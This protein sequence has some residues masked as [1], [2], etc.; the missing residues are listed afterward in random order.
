MFHKTNYRPKFL[1]VIVRDVCFPLFLFVFLAFQ[2]VI[3]K[4]RVKR[5]SF[6][7]VCLAFILIMSVEKVNLHAADGYYLRVHRQGTA[8]TGY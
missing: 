7:I 1:A 5:H 2:Y 3:K 6:C 8:C 4:L